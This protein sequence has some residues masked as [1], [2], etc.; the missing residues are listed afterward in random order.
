[1]SLLQLVRSLLPKI[2][3]TPIVLT[4]LSAPVLR[5]A[6]AVLLVRIRTATFWFSL[7]KM[8]NDHITMHLLSYAW[9]LP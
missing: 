2:S 8:H 4:N 1:M 6:D 5:S 7:T 3:H 9:H